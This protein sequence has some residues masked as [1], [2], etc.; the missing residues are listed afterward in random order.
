MITGIVLASGFSKRMK[1]DK[2]M[3]EIN[4]IP[5]VE[6]VIKACKDSKLDEIIL[7]YRTEEV[8][9]LGRKYGVKTIYNPRAYLGQSE[10]VKLG[11]KVAKYSDAFMFLVGDQPFIN[12]EIINQ[13]IKAYMEDEFSIVVPYYNGNQGMPTIFPAI[14]RKN[15]MNIEGDKGGRDIIKKGADNVKK[16]YFQDAK[17]G[18]DIDNMEE[19]QSIN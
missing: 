15:F 14:Y 10:G 17:L 19:L 2:L 9:K 1:K 8:K 4:G 6:R 16:V 11:I 3:M 13:L 5:M 12:S 7:I 18:I